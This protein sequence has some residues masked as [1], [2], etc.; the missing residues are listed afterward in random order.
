MCG[1]AACATDERVFSGLFVIR[2]NK[3]ILRVTKALLPNVL[4]CYIAAV[5]AA[6]AAAGFDLIHIRG[7]GGGSLLFIYSSLSFL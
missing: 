6:A 1:A 3:L 7:S 2:F 5:M 4:P